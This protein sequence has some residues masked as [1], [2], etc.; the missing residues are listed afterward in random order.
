[1]KEEVFLT[2][3]EMMGTQ[4][5]ITIMILIWGT[6]LLISSP[7]IYM[8]NKTSYKSK[9]RIRRKGRLENE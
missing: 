8:L 6:T 5:F 2:T 9:H 7:I 3:F 4:G 1:M